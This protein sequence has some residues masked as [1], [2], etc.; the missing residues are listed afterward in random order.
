MSSN[1]LLVQDFN[2]GVTSEVFQYNGKTYI[3]LLEYDPKQDMRAFLYIYEGSAIPSQKRDYVYHAWISTQGADFSGRESSTSWYISH[4]VE[5]DES[6]RPLF[7]DTMLRSFMRL[8][9]NSSIASFSVGSPKQIIT[10]DWL[11]KYRINWVNRNTIITSKHWSIC[12]DE[13]PLN[14]L[15]TLV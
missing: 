3:A 4:A 1:Q 8:P 15:L 10:T 14:K 5:P 2:I 12:P 11:N 7:L 9:Q 13:T 6:L